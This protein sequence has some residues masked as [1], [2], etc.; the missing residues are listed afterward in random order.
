MNNTPFEL[1]SS[2]V[3]YQ[4]EQRFYHYD[5]PALGRKLSVALYLPESLLK[6]STAQN[7]S[8]HLLIYLPEISSSAEETAVQSDYQRYANR[9]DMVLAIPDI[10]ADDALDCAGKLARYATEKAAV[11]QHILEELPDLLAQ[12]FNVLKRK[13]A[14]MGYGFGAT[15]ALDLALAHKTQVASV[16]MLAPWL[17]FATSDWF[18]KQ[19]VNLPVTLDPLSH[20]LAQQTCALPIWIDQGDADALLGQQIE[21]QPLVAHLER[22]EVSFAQCTLRWCPRYDHSYYFVHSHIR[23]HLVFASQFAH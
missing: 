5:S 12:Q 9:Y 21:L 23:E 10:F 16:S 13:V 4:G 8:H 11:A 1:L 22:E 14:L 18:K 7:C 2:H 20:L 19:S 17:G 6:H 15:V 3:S